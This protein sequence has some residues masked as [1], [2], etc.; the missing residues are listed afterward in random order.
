MA[1]SG[2]PQFASLY[3]GDLH[4]DVTEAMLYEI[5]NSVGPVGSIRV[6]RDTVTRKSLGYGYVN[7]HS[8]GDAERALDTLNYSS[9]KG[10]ACRIM[11]S[12]RDPSLRKSGVG[13]IFVKNLDPNIDNKALYDTFSLFGNILSCKVACEPGGKSRGYGFVHYETEEAAKQAIERVNGMQIGEKT[14]E[15]TAFLKRD[16]RDSADSSNFT[17]IYAKNLPKDFNDD[18]LTEM[19]GSFGAITS[20]RVNEDAKGRKFA[21]VNYETSDQ[22]KAAVEAL[23]KKD[24]RTSEDKEKDDKEEEEGPDGPSHLLY[25]ARALTKAERAAEFSKNK[26]EDPSKPAG[27]NL[28]VKNLDETIDDAALRALFEAFGTISS[29]SAVKDSGDKCKGFGFVAFSSPDE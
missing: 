5:F 14:V 19:F 23:H 21:F 3:V 29:V 15:V 1:A 13:N 20:S 11:W 9:I 10:R 12:Q 22:A 2:V 26:Q 16:S 4:P 7:F 28:Y 25:V 27:V 24:L 8:V 17:N 6:C 18:K